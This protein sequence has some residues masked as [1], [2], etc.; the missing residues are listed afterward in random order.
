MIRF[1]VTEGALD[2]VDSVLIDSIVLYNNESPIKTI[3]DFSGNVVV[4][5]TGVGDYLVISF[6]DLSSAAY[7]VTSVSLKSGNQ[8]VA[9][10]SDA[11]NIIKADSKTLNV[12]LTCQFDKAYKCY[13][14]ST[15]IGLPYATDF[16]QGVVRFAK[17]ESEPNKSVTV[18]SAKDTDDIIQSYIHGTDQYVPWDIGE[19]ESS[20][21]G[22]TTVAQ[23]KFTDNYSDITNSHTS[24]I[25][26]HY[27][28]Q[29]NANYLYF[30]DYIGGSAVSSTPMITASGVTGSS[31]LVTENYISDIYSSSVLSNSD[32]ATNK[33]VSGTAVDNYV[34]NKLSSID[35]SYVHIG[36]TETVTGAKT[37]ST[38][39][40]F[41]TSVS[42]PSYIGT[43]VYSAYTADTWGST[44]QNARIPTVASVRGAISAAET[45]ITS[46]YQTADS[47]LQSQIDA[48]N[49]GQNLAD[50]VNTKQDLESLNSSLLDVNDKVQILH[51]KTN[52]DGLIDESSTGIPTVYSLTEG[53]EPYPDSRDITAYNKEGFYWHYV[54]E[55]GVD[56]YTKSESSSL[57]VAK[58][59]LD[60]TI[61][62]T[63]SNTNAPSTLAVYNSLSSLGS[64]YVKLTSSS[65]QTITSPITIVGDT[66]I[67]D[68]KITG[69]TLA[70]KDSITPN[71]F[72]LQPVTNG[73][74]L[75]YII[76]GYS[77]YTV[78]YIAH[79]YYSAAGN[80]SLS[81]NGL[82]NS[83]LITAT[84]EQT[85]TVHNVSGNAVANYSTAGL[86]SVTDGRLTTV[87][88]VKS[89]VH[90]TTN[91][92]KLDASN[93]FTGATNTF[94]G[95]SAT[96][97]TG[98]GVYNTYESSTWDTATDKI[99]TVSSV[100][101][102]I[103]NSG[104][105]VLTGISTVNAVG[106]LGLFLYTEFDSSTGIG[107]EKAIGDQ[108]NGAYLK[109]VGMSL[110]SSGQISYKAVNTTTLSGTWKLLS[111]ALKRTSSE[112]CLVLA[113]KI[114][115]V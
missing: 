27:D 113:Q 112:P 74:R 67:E 92:A 56:S 29:E 69:S 82:E 4:D 40:V 52:S 97:Y 66:Y 107:V 33:L 49:A 26:L 42:S 8:I 15:T 103:A 35:S 44:S 17:R 65:E 10:S 78:G 90:S 96:S 105:A 30:S 109:P 55:Y 60:Q 79:H 24:S 63:S 85:N 19:S 114:S 68:F 115:D 43:G 98:T 88:Y 61:S 38:A 95:I 21:E 83:I 58:A 16:R 80:L 91:F 48:L 73:I 20:I 53:T 37:F 93:D 22:Y 77:S 6:T 34:T 111:V 51:D 101:S 32:V 71:R 50:I 31:K 64:G 59:S 18:Y 41:N 57:F 89:L 99:P 84:R 100:R 28:I 2:T 110:P 11:M 87:D 7:T 39:T 13:F 25:S 81:A 47:N 45:S 3:S 54:G 62:S 72:S 23:L 36:G 108:I 106:A 70:L 76:S 9:R 1:S 104:G 75:S 94:S 14:N 86:S 46:A 12:R 102:A 5:G